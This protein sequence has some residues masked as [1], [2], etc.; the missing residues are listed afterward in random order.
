MPDTRNLLTL[1]DW[2]SVR[3]VDSSVTRRRVVTELHLCGPMTLAELARTTGR[4]RYRLRRQLAALRTR[5]L[6]VRVAL[7]PSPRPR[8]ERELYALSS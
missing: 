3:F 2:S 4:S 1:P 7:E 8:D 5:D 6:V